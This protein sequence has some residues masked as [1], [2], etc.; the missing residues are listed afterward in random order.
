ME[1]I[2]I[3]VGRSRTVE[4]KG[5][6]VRTAI[7]KSPLLATAGRV[8]VER[9]GVAGD[10]QANLEVH[11]G[12]DKAIY[13]YP[14]EHYGPWGEEL[15]AIE[16]PWGAFGE[17]LTT[18]GD[19]LVESAVRIGDRLRAGSVELVVTQPRLPC[20]KLGLRLGTDGP[21]RR[22][23]ETDRCGFYCA[24][25][26]EGEVEVGDPVTIAPGNDAAPTVVEVFRLRTG[27]ALPENADARDLLRRAAAAP[28][29]PAAWREHFRARLEA[30]DG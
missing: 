20:Y 26:R 8:R 6:S 22:M 28:A 13:V 11:G 16:L 21:I 14:S 3:N 10:E 25:E 29:L 1:L 7:F 12:V 27:G 4:W 5:K 2:S 30:D 24:V 15:P 19:E 17:N 9:L 23:V 18:G